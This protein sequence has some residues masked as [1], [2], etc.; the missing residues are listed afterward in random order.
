MTQTR[1][2]IITN[3][4]VIVCNRSIIFVVDL[5]SSILKVVKF[6]TQFSKSPLLFVRAVWFSSHRP[7]TSDSAPVASVSNDSVKFEASVGTK[8]IFVMWMTCLLK[9][10]TLMKHSRALLLMWNSYNH[11]TMNFNQ[12]IHTNF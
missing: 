12:W 5:V 2:N 9:K 7:T 4:W 6:L 8:L 1:N 11:C 3:P 10:V